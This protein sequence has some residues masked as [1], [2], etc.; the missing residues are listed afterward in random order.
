MPAVCVVYAFRFHFFFFVLGSTC[1]VITFMLHENG[2]WNW[3]WF[4][5]LAIQSVVCPIIEHL[6]SNSCSW[7]LVD[8]VDSI[9]YNLFVLLLLI[10]C[11]CLQFICGNLWKVLARA[12]TQRGIY[13]QAKDC[14]SPTVDWHSWE[15]RLCYL[16][17]HLNIAAAAYPMR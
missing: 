9:N 2:R 1:L 10:N 12:D 6:L 7:I 3:N 15:W 4:V 16:K 11:F 13:Y 17:S 14:S 8:W 5:W